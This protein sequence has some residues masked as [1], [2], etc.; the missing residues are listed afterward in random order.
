VRLSVKKSGMK[1][2]NATNLDRKSGEAAQ[3]NLEI[4][5]LASP[6]GMEMDASDSAELP[7]PTFRAFLLM[8]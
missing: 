1:F 3:A 8:T 6:V 5:E 4:K 2:A 7:G